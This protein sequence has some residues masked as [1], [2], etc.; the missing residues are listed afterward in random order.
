MN[1][2]LKL[3][4]YELLIADLEAKLKQAHNDTDGQV[5]Q[6]LALTDILMAEILRVSGYDNLLRV[7]KII[8][9]KVY[10]GR[11]NYEDYVECNYC[12]EVSA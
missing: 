2:S 12:S 1:D 4:A 10:N 3:K 8:D 5:S 11:R 7:A 9:K 6:K